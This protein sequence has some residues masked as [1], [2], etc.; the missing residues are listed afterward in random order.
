M[1]VTLN[2]APTDALSDALRAELRL[3]L[4]VA[5]EGRCS[6]DDWHHALGGVHVWLSDAGRVISHASVV[7]RSLVCSSRRLQVGYVEGVATAAA[8]RR[9]GYGSIV[10]TR[11][12][13]IIADRY[14][15]GALSTGTPALYA[16][17]GWERWCGATFVD[18]PHGRERTANEDGGI[19]VLRTRRS[20]HLDLDGDIACDWRPGDAW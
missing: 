3:L 11:V 13:E 4:D 6:N 1:I 5:F 12:G 19:M 9:K 16:K 20:P 17:L 10:M 7:E 15:L 2:Q 18:G 8:H 14:A